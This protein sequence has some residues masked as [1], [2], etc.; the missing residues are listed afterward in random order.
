MCR[1]LYILL[2]QMCEMRAK[3]LLTLIGL[4][5][6]GGAVWYACNPDDDIPPPASTDPRL[7]ITFDPYFNGA[8]MHFGDRVVNAH[9][10]TVEPTSLKF[11]I[12][13][14]RLLREGG[15][16]LPLADIELLDLRHHKRSINYS[17]EAGAYTGLA[18]DLGV[19]VEMNG[20]QNPAFLTSMYNPAHPLSESNGMYWVWNTGY[21]FFA[22]EGRF[23]TAA[24]PRPNLPFTFGFHTG[25]DTLYR[26]LGPFN[27]PFQIARGQNKQMSFAVD[28]D[29]IFLNGSSEVNLWH[30]REFHG[31]FSQLPLGIRLAD[32]SA[33]AIRLRP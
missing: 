13:N 19:P 23:D 32:N 4:V 26:E 20:T 2:Q 1:K 5:L 30:E 31:S 16:T 8:E 3:K 29:K 25:L 10:C 14:L 15:E 27:H 24:T 33:A 28:L 22:F 9:G 17:I 12:A 7:W 21:R 6:V 18:F 11:Y